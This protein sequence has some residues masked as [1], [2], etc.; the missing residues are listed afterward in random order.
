MALYSIEESSFKTWMIAN[1][2]IWG[3]IPTL[4]TWFLATILI[5]KFNPDYI[6]LMAWGLW[7]IIGSSAIFGLA[8]ENRAPLVIYTA[9]FALPF[10]LL[11]WHFDSI[12]LTTGMKVYLWICLGISVFIGS[13]IGVYSYQ[14]ADEVLDRLFVLMSNSKERYEA[15][16]SIAYMRFTEAYIYTFIGLGAFAPIFG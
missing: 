12:T 9:I 10:I 7:I 8:Q 15:E 1:M 5:G 4:S 16:I 13:I 3:F 6:E 11:L 14:N 2:K